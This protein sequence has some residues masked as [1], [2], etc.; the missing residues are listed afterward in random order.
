MATQAE[1]KSLSEL[2]RE[3]EHTRADLI[4]TVDELHTRVSP[5]AIKEEVKAYARDTG[6]ELL[7]TLERKARQNPLQTVAV[8][9]GLAYPAWRLLINIPAP[10]LLVGAGLALSQFGGSSPATAARG[11]NAPSRMS[12]GGGD[13]EKV[14]DSLKRT[15]QNASANLSHAAEGL[16]EKVSAAADQAKSSLTSGLEAA[17]SRAAAAISNTTESALT[18]GSST[19]TAATEAVSASYRSGIDAASR[20]SD[21]LSE[22]FKQSRKGL[23]DAIE[24]HPFLVG[25]VGLVLGAVLASAL[26]VTKT[27]NRLFGDTSDE[28]KNRARD[29]ASEGLKTAKT[30]AQDVYRESVSRAQE[31]GLTPEA[32]EQT[33]RAVG[34]KVTNVVRRATE[35]LDEPEKDR[36]LGPGVG[37]HRRKGNLWRSA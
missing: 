20:T 3:A 24:N 25:G 7:H 23:F 10:I 36:P 28:L 35:A 9:A 34:D 4:H 26:P 15:V 5:H 16:K 11:A 29:M 30:A 8:A 13:G 17:R 6:N 2:E 21:Q 27:E 12:R 33:V 31:E 19:K 18:A 22:S 32:V 14:T 1:G 37:P